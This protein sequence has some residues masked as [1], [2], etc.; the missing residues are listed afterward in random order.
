VEDFYETQRDGH[1]T[2][3]HL[4]QYIFLSYLV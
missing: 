1:A 2:R 3:G 4:T